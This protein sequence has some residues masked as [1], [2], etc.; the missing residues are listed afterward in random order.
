MG[1]SD[2][3]IYLSVSSLCL[4]DVE[5]AGVS[6]SAVDVEGWGS[7]IT[8]LSGTSDVC[9]GNVDAIKCI[10]NIRHDVSGYNTVK[11]Y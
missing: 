2:A 7:T 6:L 11:W 3:K 10:S 4:L 5:G 9:S 8:W 1:S